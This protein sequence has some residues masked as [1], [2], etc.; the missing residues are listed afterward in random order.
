[1]KKNKENYLDQVSSY[2]DWDRICTLVKIISKT[3]RARNLK[4]DFD[5]ELDNHL[6]FC[7]GYDTY[8]IEK[9]QYNIYLTCTD[10]GRRLVI[11]YGLD[12]LPDYEQTAIDTRFANIKVS[13]GM[14]FDSYVEL[15]KDI[16]WIKNN[17]DVEFLKPSDLEDS[18]VFFR[19]SKYDYYNLFNDDVIGTI[20]DGLPKTKPQVGLRI[21]EYVI[22]DDT[23]S[24][25]SHCG[26]KIKS[27]EELEK[28]NIAEEKAKAIKL[29][30][31]SN[32]LPATKES[33]ISNINKS[34]IV[35]KTYQQMLEDSKEAYENLQCL[36]EACIF[37]ERLKDHSLGKYLFNRTELD[38]TINLLCEHYKADIAQFEKERL[39]RLEN[40]ASTKS[41]K[42]FVKSLSPTELRYAEEEIRKR[43]T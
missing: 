9:D 32:L 4:F 24:I 13:S 41:V 25:I 18:N 8:Y 5:D 12:E 27:P 6:E 10:D 1:M 35:K 36:Q 19:T 16:D 20:G 2:Y 43:R 34:M 29:I 39:A 40:S 3:T 38:M 42:G 31:D 11:S 17:D 15:T 33:L 23:K 21:G 22:S 7:L 28:L 37:R 30:K 26:K 14:R